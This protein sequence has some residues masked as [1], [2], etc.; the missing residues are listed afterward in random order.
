MNIFWKI[1]LFA[2]QSRRKVKG[3]FPL[4]GKTSLD[5]GAVSAS[6]V[7]NYSGSGVDGGANSS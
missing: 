3:A 7:T 6:K 4:G 1:K 5:R 2:E